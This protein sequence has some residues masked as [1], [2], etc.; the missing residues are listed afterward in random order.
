MPAVKLNPSNES[1]YFALHSFI[2]SIHSLYS[3]RSFHSAAVGSRSIPSAPL[4]RS[5]SLRRSVTRLSL[6]LCLSFPLSFRVCVCSSREMGSPPIFAKQTC[7]HTHRVKADSAN[8]SLGDTGCSDFGF[9]QTGSGVILDC[10]NDTLCAKSDT[11]YPSNST[12]G[13]FMKTLPFFPN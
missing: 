10:M 2:L 11:F 6:S 8:Q 12:C 9:Q 3:S 4:G 13:H 7:I 1:H 5:K